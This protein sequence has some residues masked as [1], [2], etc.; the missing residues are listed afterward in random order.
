LFLS[1]DD[2]YGYCSSRGR[3][4][5]ARRRNR[6]SIDFSAIGAAAV[7][8]ALMGTVALDGYA[9]STLFPS[10]GTSHVVHLDRSTTHE[11]ASVHG[12][13]AH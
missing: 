6:S 1:R 7:L 5:V 4:L 10:G 2:T 12:H 11:V 3:H 9:F 8:L 13:H